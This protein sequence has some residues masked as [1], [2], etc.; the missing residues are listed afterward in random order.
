MVS[1][2]GEDDASTGVAHS[3][4][5]CE[6]TDEGVIYFI[7]CDEGSV[8]EGSFMTPASASEFASSI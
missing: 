7:L 5:A 1:V 2:H 4:S 8:A 6:P 3:K